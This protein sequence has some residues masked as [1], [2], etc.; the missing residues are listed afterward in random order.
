ML[1]EQTPDHAKIHLQSANIHYFQRDLS[2]FLPK[3]EE[4]LNDKVLDLNGIYEVLNRHMF[5]HRVIAI[6]NDC[7]ATSYKVESIP[8]WFLRKQIVINQQQQQSLESLQNAN[9]E[10]YTENFLKTRAIFTC[11]KYG[12]LIE[13][14][15][16][17][18]AVDTAATDKVGAADMINVFEYAIKLLYQI[19]E[20]RQDGME[21]W[22]L[23]A[24]FI[25]KEMQLVD[26]FLFD[27]TML[28]CGNA[29]KIKAVQQQA[30]FIKMAFALNL[31]EQ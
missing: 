19:L 13:A 14:E 15:K 12:N 5:I 20:N 26:R 1:T 31:D 21:H 24:L 3:L 22:F 30:G 2:D 9:H 10:I 29:D 27:K 7:Q 23:L 11:I 16:L 25:N 18:L 28:A 17:L 6:I 8:K 4:S